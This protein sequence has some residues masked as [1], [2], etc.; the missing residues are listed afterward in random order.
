VLEPLHLSLTGVGA[1]YLFVP[2]RGRGKKNAQQGDRKKKKKKEGSKSVELD[3]STNT[4]N[5]ISLSLLQ[6]SSLLY[7][8][9]RSFARA[10][11]LLP[12]RFPHRFPHR[13]FVIASGGGGQGAPRKHRDSWKTNAVVSSSTLINR[14]SRAGRLDEAKTEFDE[15]RPTLHSCPDVKAW[16]IRISKLAKAGELEAMEQALSK[17][18]QQ[19]VQPNVVTFNTMLNAYAFGM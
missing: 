10:R 17:M 9:L 6:S 12:P 5:S 18:R 7:M 8:L 3:H 15:K 4:P 14:Q 11:V 19:G 1:C 2:S 13:A 16:T